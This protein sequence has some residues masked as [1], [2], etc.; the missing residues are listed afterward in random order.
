MG[1]LSLELKHPSMHSPS[2]SLKVMNEWSYIYLLPLCA[3]VAWKGRL[4]LSYRFLCILSALFKG[5]AGIILKVLTMPGG[6]ATCLYFSYTFLLVLKLV[7]SVKFYFF[8]TCATTVGT[9]I[10]VSLRVV[11]YSYFFTVL[12]VLWALIFLWLH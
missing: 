6:P 8:F 10:M 12:I 7:L 2:S 11:S 1:D 5:I 4:Y 9:D 3:F